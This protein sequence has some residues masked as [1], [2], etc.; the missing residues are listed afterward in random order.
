MKYAKQFTKEVG[1]IT[2]TNC[3]KVVDWSKHSL[4]I[5]VEHRCV[6]EGQPSGDGAKAA[7]SSLEK[8]VIR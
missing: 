3:S 2:N 6:A 4:L 7:E 5:K 8:V 1:A